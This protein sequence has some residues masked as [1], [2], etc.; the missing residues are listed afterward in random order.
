MQRYDLATAFENIWDDLKN[1]N[2]I[3]CKNFH[4]S[5]PVLT[6][7][8]GLVFDNKNN[9]SAAVYLYIRHQELIRINELKKKWK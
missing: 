5:N 2:S 3:P 6:Q 9:M 4:I 7:N 1:F 8:A